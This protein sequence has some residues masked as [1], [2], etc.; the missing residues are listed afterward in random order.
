[1]AVVFTV[2]QD[3]SFTGVEPGLTTGAALPVAITSAPVTLA[4]DLK[5]E[6]NLH[7]TGNT[8]VDGTINK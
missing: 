4:A 2:P 3:G 5:I 7:V 6:G 1:M 8:V